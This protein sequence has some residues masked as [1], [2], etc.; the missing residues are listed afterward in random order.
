MIDTSSRL[1]AYGLFSPEVVGTVAQV[2]DTQRGFYDYVDYFEH[3]GLPI[4]HRFKGSEI[5]DIIPTGDFDETQALVYHLPMANSIDENMAFQAATIHAAIP[6]KRLIAVGNPGAPGQS[7]GALPIEDRMKVAKG[8][9]RPTIEPTL[10]YLDQERITRTQH[11]GYS[12]G[13]EK[14]AVATIFSDRYNQEVSHSVH[15]EPP[16]VKSRHLIELGQDFSLAEDHL[17]HYVEASG[18]RCFN[19]ARKESAGKLMFILGLL[20][21]TNIA[22]ARGL[23]KPYFEYRMNAA[24]NKQSQLQASIVWGSESEL[25]TDGLVEAITTNLQDDFGPHRVKRMRLPGQFHAFP[26][27]IHLQAAVVLQSIAAKD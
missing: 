6:D 16:S 23:T 8:N 20:R 22:I 14:A 15:I 7:L 17:D 13:A 27:D 18:V 12:Y 5:L 9:L 3:I 24:L 1:N 11:V 21:P 10:E 26:N 25:A 2:A 19:E 4:P